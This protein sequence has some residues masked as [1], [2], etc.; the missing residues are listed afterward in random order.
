[1]AELLIKKIDAVH[2]DI[3]KDRRGCYK[4]GDIVQVYKDGEC[5]ESPS[6]NSK[7]YIVKVSG[8]SKKEAEKYTI[9]TIAQRR[10][11]HFD[12]TG[13]SSVALSNLEINRELSITSVQAKSYIKS[14]TKQV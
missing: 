12:F 13:L 3:V 6:P 9:S 10:F 1:M 4:R 14:K 8:M 2:K 11:Y 5:K 7:M